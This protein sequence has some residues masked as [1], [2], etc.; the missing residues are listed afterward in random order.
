[1]TKM[2]VGYLA[3]GMLALGTL[4]ASPATTQAANRYGVIGLT[5]HTS[6]T[7]KYKYKI[8]SKGNWRSRSIAPGRKQWFSHRYDFAGENRS[9]KF[10]IRF[11]SDLRGGRT[12]YIQYY[13]KRRAAVGQGYKYGKKY[14]FQY[15]KGDRR[16]A[17]L[18]AID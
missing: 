5:N 9:T 15:D 13:L 6:T 18:K 14:A 11:D 8:G 17:D 4:V 16:F 2:F 10:Y 12:F 1:M 3:A 7:I